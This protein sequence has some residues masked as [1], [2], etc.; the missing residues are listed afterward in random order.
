MFQHEQRHQQQRA[1]AIKQQCTLIITQN[2]GL[3]RRQNRKILLPLSLSCSLARSLSFGRRSLA[4]LAFSKKVFSQKYNTS[5]PENFSNLFYTKSINERKLFMFL[6]GS[7]SSFIS[8][9]A[10]DRSTFQRTRSASECRQLAI[11]KVSSDDN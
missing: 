1:I 8:R 2:G 4:N 9:L 10:S 3:N 5:E 11:V 7:S 6:Q